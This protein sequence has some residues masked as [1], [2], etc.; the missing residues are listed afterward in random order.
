[1]QRHLKSN[2][3]IKAI[4]KATAIH[5]ASYLVWSAQKGPKTNRLQCLIWNDWEHWNSFG[6][7]QLPLMGKSVEEVAIEKG[8]QERK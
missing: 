5:T 4:I 2:R 3:K 7:G 8:E 6:Q 1:V